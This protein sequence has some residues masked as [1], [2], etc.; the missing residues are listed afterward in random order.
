M[1]AS[2]RPGFLDTN[3][4]SGVRVCQTALERGLDIGGSVFRIGGEPYTPG[5]A[6]VFTEAG[7]TAFAHYAMTE[8]G[9]IGM[10]CGVPAELDEV[11]VMDDKIAMIDRPVAVG[12]SGVTVNALF[13]TSLLPSSQKLMLNVESGD[14]GMSTR[15]QCGCPLEHLGFRRHLH[16]I[17]SYEKLSSEG[18]HFI[19]DDLLA[20]VDELLPARFG[21]SSTDYQFVEREDNGLPRVAL[22]VSPRLGADRRAGDRARRAGRAGVRGRRPRDDG[23]ALGGRPHLENRSARAVFDGRGEDSVSA[24]RQ[25]LMRARGFTSGLSTMRMRDVDSGP[26]RLRARRLRRARRSE[27]RR[28]SSPSSY[29]LSRS[30]RLWRAPVVCRQSGARRRRLYHR[31]HLL[32]AARAGRAGAYPGHDRSVRRVQSNPLGCGCAGSAGTVRS[33]RACGTIT[34]SSSRARSTRAVSSISGESGSPGRQR[35]APPC[36]AT[37]SGQRVLGSSPRFCSLPARPT[38]PPRS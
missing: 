27:G 24:L 32:C 33:S 28:R 26:R 1:R 17:R 19:G 16:R 6:R 25:T 21:G 12:Q 18:M 22:I 37:T 34:C 36:S 11:H 20:I 7:C 4:A 23:P 38:A 30:A 15:R 13:L 14:Y 2:G 10:A 29:R 5:K 3:A 35:W 9:L 31:D 8:A